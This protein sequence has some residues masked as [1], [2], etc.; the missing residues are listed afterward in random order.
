VDLVSCLPSGVAMLYAGP[1]HLLLPSVDA[2]QRISAAHLRRPRVLA[3]PGQ[4]VA[5]VE[6]MAAV[7]MLTFTTSPLCVNGLFGVPKG[8]DQ[9]RLILDARRANCYF[10]DP[11]SVELPSPSH[12]AALRTVSPL[13]FYVAKLD[14]S[15]F[16]HQLVLPSWLCP[17]FALPALSMSDLL[18]LRRRGVNIACLPNS[19]D[20]EAVSVYPCCTTLPMG[21]SHSVFLAQAVHEHV[22]YRC[23]AL[24]PSDNVIN[25]LSPVLDRPVHGIYIDDLCILGPACTPCQQ[26]FDRALAAYGSCRLPP[27]SPGSGKLQRASSSV[28]TVLGVDINPA[29]GRIALSPDRHQRL[30]VAT[31]RLLRRPTVSGRHLSAL[32][33]SWTWPMLLNR[34]TLAAIK[35][36][37][38]FAQRFADSPRLLWP[39]VR[40]ELAVLL[41]LA[42]LLYADV[43]APEHHHVFASDSSAFAAGVVQAPLHTAWTRDVW[44]VVTLHECALLPSSEPPFALAYQPAVDY[45]RASLSVAKVAGRAAATIQSMTWTTIISSRWRRPAHINELE[46]EAVLLALRAVLSSPIAS[47]S[48]RRLYLVTDSSVAYHALRKGR[49]SSP[50]LLRLLRRCSA[51]ALGGGLSLAFVWVPSAVNPADSPSRSALRVLR[52]P[53]AF[54]P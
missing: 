52:Q 10:I 49:S 24:S 13:P 20:L 48:R 3:A 50:A 15:N 47:A 27:A 11:P 32:L 21:F 12:L 9:Q 42:P 26:Q 5:L 6:R 40:R 29:T 16:Y 53:D 4:Y 18:H 7:G 38:N 44:P 31:Y 45:R 28:T 41:A 23:G 17:Y 34:P 36:S 51:L 14:L 37:Y 33:G 46:L 2:Q 8:T 43:T 35:H 19:L 1:Q 54:T 30:V 39:C 25:L 22:L